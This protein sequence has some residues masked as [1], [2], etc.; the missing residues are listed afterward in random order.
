MSAETHATVVDAY[1]SAERVV[2]RLKGKT[3][4]VEAFRIRVGGT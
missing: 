2:L 4:P 3:A 1:P